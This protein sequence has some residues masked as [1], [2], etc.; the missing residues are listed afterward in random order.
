MKKNTFLWILVALVV[1]FFV[2]GM[3]TSVY[4]GFASGSSTSTS[5]PKCPEVT[6]GGKVHCGIR[7]KNGK[8]SIGQQKV[9][10]TTCP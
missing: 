5:P 7:G 8:C 6:R 9:N 4:E 3:G 10:G 1:F 2:F